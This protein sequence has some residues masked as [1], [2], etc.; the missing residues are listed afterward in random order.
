MYC[1]QAR[2]CIFQ[3]GKLT[4]WGSEGVKRARGS[5]KEGRGE[6]IENVWDHC[7]EK[8]TAPGTCI[9]FRVLRSIRRRTKNLRWSIAICF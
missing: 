3:P 1:L 4:G 2:P 9:L 6:V 5:D 7:R 8:L